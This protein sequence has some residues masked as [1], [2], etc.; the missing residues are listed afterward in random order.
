MGR[1]YFAR[2]LPRLFGHRG[3]AGIAP[4]NTM[5]SFRQALADGADYLE[6]DVHAT[7]DGVVVVIHDSTLERTTNGRGAVR[8]LPFSEIERLDAG[9]RFARDGSY[10]FRE[11]GVRVPALEELLEEFP[12]V[13][14]NIE[15]K[16]AEP[17]VEPAVVS[18]L[19]RKG[20]LERSLLAAEDDQ[21]MRRIRSHAPG[22]ATSASF[23]EV[24]DFFERCFAD[25]FEGYAPEARAL[26]I[27]ERFGDIDLVSPETLA[28]ARR[29]GLETHVWTVNEE[30]AIE[31]LLRLGVDG[32]MSDFPSRLVAVARRSSARE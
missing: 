2:P 7:R 26:Q 10:P 24:R 29:F 30:S 9:F 20:A 21:I 1:G 22:V 15:I 6:L 3:A 5:A 27:P 31:R 28:A 17:A 16:Q 4:E 32:L 23:G 8:D 25:R 18:L 12:E 11:Q 13:P 14:L 19:V